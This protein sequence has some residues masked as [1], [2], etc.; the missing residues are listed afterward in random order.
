PST[1]WVGTSFSAW[2]RRAP[3]VV[4]RVAPRRRPR[5]PPDGAA[6]PLGCRPP[7]VACPLVRLDG[8]R[9]TLR[10]WRSDDAGRLSELLV[11]ERPWHATNGPYRARLAAQDLDGQRRRLP[12]RAKQAVLPA[13]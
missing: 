1:G 2:P 7:R 5:S 8:E 6:T 4:T 13:P 3:R 11:P 9:V 10:D 12:H